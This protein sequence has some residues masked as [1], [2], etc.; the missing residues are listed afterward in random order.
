MF[1]HQ[2]AIGRRQRHRAARSTFARDNSDGGNAQAQAGLDR[3]CDRFGLSAFFCALAGIGHRACR[4][5]TE[6]A[7]Q[8]GPP[9]PSSGWLCDT[10]QADPC[11]SCASRANSCR[12]LFSWPMTTTARPRNR[13]NPPRS[14]LI[15][16]EVTIPRQGLIIRQQHVGERKKLGAIGVTRNLAFLPRIKVTVD[17]GETLGP[18]ARAAFP[19][20]RSSRRR[21]LHQRAC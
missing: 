9:A 8:T 10:P 5:R 14:R 1:E 12:G 19:A 13:A 2:H 21:F 17:L 15:V 11:Q 6:P 16:A 7:S 20:R 3:S 4:Q 18:P